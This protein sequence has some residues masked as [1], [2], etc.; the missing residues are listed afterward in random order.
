MV[1][2]W[3]AVDARP[4]GG[5]STP[6][7]M[8]VEW[9]EMDLTG[10][11]VLVGWHHL[12][13]GGGARRGRFAAPCARRRRPDVVSAILADQSSA[14]PSDRGAARCGVPAPARTE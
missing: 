4:P 3:P 13:A 5:G 9:P 8:A 7:P 1:V 10:Q 12:A 11:S 6:A 14:P 2:G